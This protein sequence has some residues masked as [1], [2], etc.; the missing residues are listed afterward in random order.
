[1]ENQM[2]FYE[3]HLQRFST[4]YLQF[5]YIELELR[6]RVVATLSNYAKRKSY[7]E[8]FHI[9][10]KEKQFSLALRRALSKNRGSQKEFE[11]FLPFSFWKDLFHKKYFLYLWVPALHKVFL[12]LANPKNLESLKFMSKKLELAH[13]IRNRLAHYNFQDSGNFE[14]EKEVLESVITALGG[15]VSSSHS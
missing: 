5:G 10:P 8:W 9:I 14:A 12:G 7:S 13:Q 2:K 3:L 15:S 11:R 6:H 4:L 1:M